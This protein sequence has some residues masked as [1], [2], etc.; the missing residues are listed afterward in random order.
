MVFLLCY[1]RV[2]CS[3]DAGLD[4]RLLKAVA[5]L[6]YVYPTLVQSKGLPLALAGKDLLVRAKTGSGKTAA[7][8]LAALQK[9]LLNKTTKRKG[10]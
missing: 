2:L 7:Y 5:R 4:R 3:A 8:G 1:P 10:A 6:G 9:I